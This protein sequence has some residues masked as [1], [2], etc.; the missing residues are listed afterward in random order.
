MADSSESICERRSGHLSAAFYVL[1]M[2]VVGVPVWWLTTTVH[3]VKLP[4]DQIAALDRD[5][6]TRMRADILLVS[7]RDQEQGPKIQA[8]LKGRAKKNHI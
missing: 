2:L 5:L 8:L 3:R 1:L 4:Y 7:P 6:Q